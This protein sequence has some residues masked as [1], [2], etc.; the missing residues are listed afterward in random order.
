MADPLPEPVA[1]AAPSRRAR[2]LTIVKIVVGVAAVALLVA[3]VASQWDEVTAALAR[4]DAPTTAVAVVAT[5]VALVA[6]MF[7]WRAVMQALGL[8]TTRRAAAS[9]FFVGQLGKYLPGGVWSIAAQA[10]LGRAHGL[11]RGPS[12]VAALTSMVIGIVGAAVVGVL[13][14]VLSSPDGLRQYWWLAVLALVGLVSLA[15]PVLGRLVGLAWRLLRR[16]TV[17]VRPTWAGIGRSLAWSVGMWV[18]YGVQATVVL[19]AFGA[20]SR[21]L[22]VTA[23]A[24]YATAWLVGFLVLVAPAGLGARE[25]VLL[26][27]LAGVTTTGGALGLAVLS[28]ALMTLGDVLL[29][30]LGLALEARRRRR[31]AP[32]G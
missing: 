31:A 12:A 28:R 15:P 14:L 29:A 4:L 27:L 13:G 8:H 22:W 26:V 20:T 17:E 23:T 10:E 11:A 24:A 21:L 32:R 25:G 18:A 9:I 6:N 7:S 2:V 30:G 3:G 1:P 5:L 19:Q 16:P